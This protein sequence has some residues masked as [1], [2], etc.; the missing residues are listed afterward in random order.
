MKSSAAAAGG[1]WLASKVLEVAKPVGG[2]RVLP[3]TVVEVAGAVSQS[4]ETILRNGP[5]AWADGSNA[6]RSAE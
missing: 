5:F 4:I 1:F 2:P 6:R 3:D